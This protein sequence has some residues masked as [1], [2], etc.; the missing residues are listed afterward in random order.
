[1]IHEVM[2]LDHSGPAF[3]MILYGAAMKLLVMGA[4]LVR[5]ALPFQ[6]GS[7]ALDLL[8]FLSGLLGL[9]VLIGV[10]ESTMARLRLPRVPQVLVGTTLLSIFALVLVLR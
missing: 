9:A 7:A 5:L 1:M 3:G 10:I 6:T 8:L 2:V 4:L